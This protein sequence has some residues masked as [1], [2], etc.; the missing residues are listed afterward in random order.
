MPKIAIS[1][2]TPSDLD[3]L[4]T[5]SWPTWACGVSSFP[6]HYDSEETCYI[7]EGRV[8]IETAGEKVEIK[9]GDLVVFPAGLDC[10]W[11]V[12]EPIR[13]VYRFA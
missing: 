2:P 7:L 13:K 3:A 12:Q 4:G 1:R 11:R 9:P 8:T 5:K 10:T 6:W